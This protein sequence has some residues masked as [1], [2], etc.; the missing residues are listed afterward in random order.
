MKNG[1]ESVKMVLFGENSCFL[2]KNYRK[3]RKNV[4]FNRKTGKIQEK[5]GEVNEKLI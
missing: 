4:V 5:V 1:Q 2:L 3:T